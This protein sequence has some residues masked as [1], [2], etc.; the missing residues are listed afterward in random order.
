MSEEDFMGE[1]H[2]PTLEESNAQ[3]VLPPNLDLEKHRDE[4]K[5][6]KL[7]KQEE[8]EFLQTLWNIMRTMAEMGWGIEQSQTILNGLFDKASQDSGKLL[9]LE[10]K[11]KLFNEKSKA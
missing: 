10:D 7:S 6:Y 8:T 9:R 4:L 2:E 1:F 3:Y 5:K 11:K